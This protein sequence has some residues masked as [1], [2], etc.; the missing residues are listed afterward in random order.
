MQGIYVG[1]MNATLS[2][3]TN[4][5]FLGDPFSYEPEKIAIDFSQGRLYSR[6]EGNYEIFVVRINTSNPKKITGF[7]YSFRADGVSKTNA[8]FFVGD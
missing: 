8:L 6:A 7:E 2:A 5:R 3:I 4:I 1:E